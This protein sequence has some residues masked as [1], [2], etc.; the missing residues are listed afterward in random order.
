MILQYAVLP[1]ISKNVKGTKDQIARQQTIV[2][3]IVSLT[4]AIVIIVAIMGGLSIVGVSSNAILT[5]AGILSLVIGLAA[6]SILKDIVNG[7]LL[8]FEN[9]MNLGNQLAINVLGASNAYVGTLHEFNIRTTTLL[10]PSGALVYIPNGTILT[11]TN[12]NQHMQ[13]VTIDVSIAYAGNVDVI[14][15]S[16][17]DL[18]TSLR[19]DSTLRTKL[20][21]GPEYVGV[22][23][24]TPGY[25][26]IQITA[27]TTPDFAPRVSRRIRGEIVRLMELINVKGTISF[28]AVQQLNPD[29]SGPPFYV[30]SFPGVA[31]QHGANGPSLGNANALQTVSATTSQIDLSVPKPVPELPGFIFV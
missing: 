5:V 20:Y 25:Y 8:L 14:A 19:R 9:Q 6:Q 1:I 31:T 17:R 30:S 15:Q 12:H 13:V 2:Y 4:N 23:S 3:A 21:S 27:S 24:I 7:L 10:T 26:V 22:T 18:C 11:V 28:A 16:F 29:P